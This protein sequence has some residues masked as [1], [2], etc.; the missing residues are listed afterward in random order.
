MPDLKRQLTTTVALGTLVIG[1][2]FAALM[3]FLFKKVK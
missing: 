2:G 3:A 1:G